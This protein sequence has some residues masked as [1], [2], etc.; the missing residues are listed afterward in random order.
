MHLDDVRII[1]GTEYAWVPLS[2]TA[3]NG[4]DEV[5]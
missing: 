4:T 2:T 1:A 5:A 3:N